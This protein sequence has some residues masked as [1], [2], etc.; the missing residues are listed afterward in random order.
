[1]AVY[2]IN[3][4]PA[5]L[6]KRANQSASVRSVAMVTLFAG[7]NALFLGFFLLTAQTVKGHAAAME[8]RVQALKTRMA[9]PDAAGMRASTNQA[10]ALLER[11]AARVVWTPAL[12]ELRTSLPVDLILERLDASVSTSTDVFSGIQLSGRLRAGSNVEPVMSYLDRLS[13]S[14]A[15]RKYFQRAKLDRVDNSQ[16]ISRFVIACPLARPASSDSS[17]EAS[18]S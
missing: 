7:L 14:P 16:E 12:N 10:R 6:A 4:Y 18:G 5:G 1:M 9:Q 17:G 2:R 13:A 8:D 11:R 15:Y 3:L